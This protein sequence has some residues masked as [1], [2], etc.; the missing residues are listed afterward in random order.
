MLRY[1]PKVAVRRICELAV[2]ACSA[3]GDA[4]ASRAERPH[5]AP[6]LEAKEEGLLK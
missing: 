3:L 6:P 2:E 1:G 5:E 4:T